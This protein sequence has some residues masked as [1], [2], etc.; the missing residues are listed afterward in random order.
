[1]RADFQRD[2]LFP[3]LQ[4]IAYSLA[5][6]A[7]ALLLYD[8]Y[9]QGLYALV[10]TSAIAV[11]AFLF[12]AIFIYINR[13]QYMHNRINYILIV[14][15]AVLALY[16]L[17]SHAEVVV[18]YIYALPLL[19][20][21]ALPLYAATFLNLLVGLAMAAIVW[22]QQD[23]W[24]ALRIGTNYGLLL[25]SAW[26]FAYLTL[27][28]GWS[29]KRLA[30]TDYYSGAYNYRHFVYAF[31]REIARSHSA[32]K[33]VSLIALCIDDY[34]MLMDIYGAEV[35]GETLPVFV[36]TTQQLIRLEDE[37]FRLGS[38]LFVLLLPNCAEEHAQVLMERIKKGL[39]EQSWG[40]IN[41]LS[42]STSA[43]GVRVGESGQEAEK[44]LKAQLKK[45]RL[46]ALQM[47]AFEEIA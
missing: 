43:L 16:Q 3:K 14:L 35:V 1:M 41:E 31:Q 32:G 47:T 36:D 2:E 6:V 34:P 39:S 40:A 19:C 33:E 27:L 15:L 30:L 5:A 28:K 37:I 10:L 12:S 45:Q 22:W 21:F 17:P 42:L 25:G 23:F 11:P 7:I 46:S 29:L 44:R 26:S 18:H 8:Q 4:V 20:F 13:H 24:A 9:R 38:D